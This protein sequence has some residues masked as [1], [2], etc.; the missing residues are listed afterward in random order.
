MRW[1]V[2]PAEIAGS[3]AVPGEKSIAH[4]S[5]ML[6]GLALG[7]SEIQNLPGGEDVRATVRCMRALGAEIDVDSDAV[8]VSSSGSLAPPNAPLDTANSGTSMRLL[9]GVLAGQ[10]FDSC[11]VGDESLSSRPM[12][13]VI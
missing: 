13:R 9:A 8:H 12:R 6:S 2:E 4:R 10:H 5:L 1:R 7:R 11:L 3:L